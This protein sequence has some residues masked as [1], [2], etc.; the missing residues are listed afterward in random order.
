MGRSL[1]MG[2]FGS[3]KRRVDYEVKELARDNPT[4][5]RSKYAF[6]RRL[7][8]AVIVD[9]S[10]GHLLGFYVGVLLLMVLGEWAINRYSP[11]SL[12][13][14][15]GDGP[16]GFLKDVGSYLIAAQV[17]LLAIVSVA[18][19]VVTLLSQR[20]DGSSINT[21]IRLYYVES[22]SR[23]LAVSAIALLIVLTLQLF[24]PLQHALHVA[25]LGGRDYSFKLALMA[26]HALWF[27]LNLVLF[28]QFIT[29]T[30]RFVEPSARET[31]RE[32]YSA[33][34]VI[35][36]D[37]RQ[38]LMRAL[39]YNAPQQMFGEE[40]LSEGPNISSVTH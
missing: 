20:D 33:N 22:Y 31:L 17:G 28:L 39:Y 35:P 40:A 24:W 18:V 32:R 9:R 27:C 1:G 12:P 3:L 25:G 36:R 37:A 19:G 14:Y 13:G 16:R 34:E 26:L 29:T 7:L 11:S 21:D 30:F 4:L 15:Y 2:L 5:R 23:E 6:S 38:R 8:R 10:M